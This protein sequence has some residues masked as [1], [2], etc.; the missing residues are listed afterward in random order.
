MT[1][2]AFSNIIRLHL[3]QDCSEISKRGG[4]F[5]RLEKGSVLS[6]IFIDPAA[7][8]TFSAA[9][10]VLYLFRGLFYLNI[11]LLMI[12]SIYLNRLT[13]SILLKEQGRNSDCTIQSSQSSL[14]DGEGSLIGLQV[15]FCI[16]IRLGDCYYELIRRKETR[17]FGP[18]FSS[19]NAGDG[20]SLVLRPTLLSCCFCDPSLNSSFDNLGLLCKHVREEHALE[21]MRLLCN[22]YPKTKICPTCNLIFGS[23]S[24][25]SNHMKR[26]CTRT[27][28]PPDQAEVDTAVPP[29]ILS[30][31]PADQMNRR[32]LRLKC[33]RY[34]AP[35]VVVLCRQLLERVLLALQEASDTVSG[36]TA[37]HITALFGIPRLLQNVR[38]D[39]NIRKTKRDI[40]TILASPD[41]LSALIRHTDDDV[42]APSL[43]ARSNHSHRS[44]NAL[45]E[46]RIRQLVAARCL[47]R[48]VR[49]VES[50]STHM[51]VVGSDEQDV[52]VELARLFPPRH[53]TD[54]LPLGTIHRETDD[55]DTADIMSTREVLHFS[56]EEVDAALHLLPVQSAG[57]FSGWSYDLVRQLSEGPEGVAVR[58]L[59]R[60]VSTLFMQGRGGPVSSWMQDR[61]VP[62]RKNSGSIRP[63]VIG[64]VWPRIFSRIAAMKLSRRLA[65]T[66]LPLQWGIGSQGGPEIVAH[67]AHLFTAR[68]E[69][70]SEMAIQ[71]LDFTNAFNT[72]R[73]R[74]VFMGLERY[75][76]SLIPWFRWCYGAPSQLWFSDGAPAARCETGVRQGDPLGC[77]LFCLGIHQ[78]LEEAQR[79]HPTL[80]I[81][82]DLDD[83]TA[84]GPV[85]EMPAFL[86]TVQRLV[87][88]LGLSLHPEKSFAWVA[89]G[90]R[91]P[92]PDLRVTRNGHRLMGTFIGG[93]E[94]Q[95][96]AIR[97]AIQ[98]FLE[99]AVTI[100]SLDP[101]VALPL[102]QCCVN[103]RP[104]HLAR[105]TPPR[106]TDQALA[107]FDHGIDQAIL[108]IAGSNSVELPEVTQMLRALP[109]AEGG[110]GMPRLHLIREAAWVASFSHATSMLAVYQPQFLSSI[111]DSEVSTA[112][113]LSSLTIVKRHVPSLFS[114]NSRPDS[115]DAADV[116]VGSLPLFW[117]SETSEVNEEA[118]ERPHIPRQKDL[119]VDFV[120]ENI[121]RTEALLRRDDD[122]CGLAW[123]L[124]QRYK[125]SG[126]WL[127]FIPRA[128]N[129]QLNPDEFRSCLGLRLLLPCCWSPP[130][131]YSQCQHCRATHY[132]DQSQ[133]SRFHALS[134]IKAQGKVTKRHNHICDI[135]ASTLRTLFG[136]HAVQVEPAM[137][138]GMR[139]PDII[140]SIGARTIIIDVAV[141]NPTC[142]QYLTHSSD[143]VPYAA[144][145]A[146]EERKRRSYIGT[147]ASLQLHP[148]ALVPFVLEATGRLGKAATTFVEQLETAVEVRAEVS[149][150]ATIKF[151][152]ANMRCSLHRGN[153][154]C[155]RFHRENARLMATASIGEADMMVVDTDLDTGYVDGDGDGDVAEYV[156][157]VGVSS[158]ITGAGVRTGT[159]DTTQYDSLFEDADLVSIAEV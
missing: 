26:P 153:A 20:P 113:L 100:S 15:L 30:P 62:L 84:L 93:V 81:L 22:L 124:S 51:G 17:L 40:S 18:A 136:K 7:I 114:S 5:S 112:H 16:F 59:I 152:L 8:W 60:G 57:S 9:L 120:R 71:F 89:E 32:P 146:L 158:S 105:T 19:D 119:C 67:A 65:G 38:G 28:L 107:E 77:L 121:A 74:P 139:R 154:I 117:P 49:L 103:T 45:P 12:K 127:T 11:H 70:N 66:L 83:V 55:T 69:D 88:P 110:L 134:C 128:V 125:G 80:T 85:A 144:A 25:L 159:R 39:A 24:A 92:V 147:L 21:D 34:I 33:V 141:A 137:P 86:D 102:L 3:R 48:A 98:A 64:E 82:A 78:A 151:M 148:D 101:S 118:V 122:R 99:T 44:A 106:L 47:S 142:R 52:V 87:V 116:G 94:Y 149:A 73:R 4:V 145:D 108:R 138:G 131:S 53:P 132:G 76:P 2:E 61:L 104:V 97:D 155:I 35:S 79:I 56:Q 1:F 29:I 95:V 6:M 46:K 143:T 75:A 150:R 63:I 91:L 129:L 14:V 23:G 109:Q 123:W 37:H 58:R 115:E 13:K 111:M 42:I 126:G 90:T 72:I 68:V 157:G 96:T 133:D 50:S 27:Q 140:L 130:G 31:A 135:L 43:P 10:E 156:T 54:D 36:I 41:L